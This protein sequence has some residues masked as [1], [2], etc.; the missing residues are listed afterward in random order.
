[1]TEIADYLMMNYYSKYKGTRTDVI[2]D[3]ETLLRGLNNHKDKVVVIRND[4]IKGVAVYVTLSDATY[5]I[6]KD[7]DI[8]REDLIIS[9]LKEHGPNVHVLMLAADGY[10]TIMM[11]IEEIK[12]RVNTDTISWWNPKQSKLH[13]FK[14]R[15]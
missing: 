8:T 11:G 6:L 12:R 3:R 15:R 7:V 13:K 14:I 2:P 10:N 1:M 9:L 4:K 5:K